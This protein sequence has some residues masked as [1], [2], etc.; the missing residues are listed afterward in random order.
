MTD[1][2]R[3]RVESIDGPRAVLMFRRADADTSL[4]LGPSFAQML[5][6]DPSS[7]GR[8][9]FVTFRDGA[10]ERDPSF[11]V[12]DLVRA[13][14]IEETFEPRD[15]TDDEPGDHGGA[16]VTLQVDDAALLGHWKPGMTW[17]TT[18]YD[19]LDDCQHFHFDDPSSARAWSRGA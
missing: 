15:D 4:P 13:M 18:A 9:D 19:E 11:S 7:P 3:V 12:K 10:E 8:G 17:G 2:F 14:T 6:E 16:R 1:L 5:L